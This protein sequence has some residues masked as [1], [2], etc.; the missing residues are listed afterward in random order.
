MSLQGY[1]NRRLDRQERIT[2]CS[3][4]EFEAYLLTSNISKTTENRAQFL[5]GQT[6]TNVNI[7]IEQT[8]KLEPSKTLRL[9]D[10]NEVS[11]EKKNAKLTTAILSV[12]HHM[13]KWYM[14]ILSFIMQWFQVAQS[15]AHEDITMPSAYS[16][17]TEAETATTHGP[18][19]NEQTN[20]S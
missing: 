16:M 6:D 8:H 2:D 9:F 17:H 19:N 18:T 14:Q 4:A 13:Q 7:S 3:L 5:D 12:V 11:G 1:T 20:V 10:L 15:E